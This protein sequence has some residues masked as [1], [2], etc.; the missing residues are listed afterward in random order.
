M[1]GG[2]EVPVGRVRM[3]AEI[4]RT[5][6]RRNIAQGYEPLSTYNNVW[7]FMIGTA[8]AVRGWGTERPPNRRIGT[9]PEQPA[10]DR[11]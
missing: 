7:S 6:G 10:R 11:Q 1:A 9:P 4:R 8:F 3:T 5:T 2:V